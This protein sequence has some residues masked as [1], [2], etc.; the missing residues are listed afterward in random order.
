MS[1]RKWNNRFGLSEEDFEA[2]CELQ[3]GLCAICERPDPRKRSDGTDYPLCV[4]HCHKTGKI[5][6]LLCTRCNTAI[7][8]FSEDVEILKRAIEYL[9]L[10]NAPHE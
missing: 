9:N 1:L 7:G 4:D 8:Q 5:R 3:E 2:M 6:A 10:H